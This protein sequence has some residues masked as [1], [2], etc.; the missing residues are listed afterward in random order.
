MERTII[1]MFKTLPLPISMQQLRFT[2]MF[3]KKTF[4][5]RVI[6]ISITYMSTSVQGKSEK[7]SWENRSM[8]TRS[9]K[10]PPPPPLRWYFN[11]L[12]LRVVCEN[13]KSCNR[14]KWNN[15]CL[16]WSRVQHLDRF[17]CECGLFWKITKSWTIWPKSGIK[18][19]SSISSPKAVMLTCIVESSE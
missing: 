13:V 8:L 18:G 15:M 10:R 19:R 14:D 12:C 4:L 3:L 7:Y 1:T 16:E 11:V 5:Y 17:Y 6:I 2:E 9:G